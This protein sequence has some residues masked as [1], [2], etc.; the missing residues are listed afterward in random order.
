MRWIPLPLALP[1][2]L[3]ATAALSADAS[4][5][6]ETLR[7]VMGLKLGGW[8]TTFT[9]K[10]LKADFPDGLNAEDAER[11]LARFRANLEK[12]R[13]KNECLS[14]IPERLNLPGVHPPKACDYSRIE[15]S[16]GKFLI[17]SLCKGDSGAS[18]EA[19]VEGEYGPERMTARSEV[20]SSNGGVRVRIKMA[21]ESRFAGQ[22][23][24]NPVA[25]TPPAEGD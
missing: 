17:K 20:A 11:A 24:S 10:D 9:V 23:S 18:L 13:I 16:D 1:L 4:L 25:E 6:P 14:D 21:A 19:V 22:C 12:D 5:R 15:A 8:Q 3:S 7:Q 2:V